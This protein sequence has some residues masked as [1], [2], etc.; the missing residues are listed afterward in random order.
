M[1]SFG[2]DNALSNGKSVGGI[3]EDSRETFLHVETTVP[4]LSESSRNRPE[5]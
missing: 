3:D 4:R 2:Q 1:E 5:L